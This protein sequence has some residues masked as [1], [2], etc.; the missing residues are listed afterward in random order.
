MF[1]LLFLESNFEYVSPIF[2]YN[3]KKGKRASNT[4]N[5]TDFFSSIAIKEYNGY[6]KFLL[7]R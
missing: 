2:I 7:C 5:N 4:F 3:K 1:H 6:H